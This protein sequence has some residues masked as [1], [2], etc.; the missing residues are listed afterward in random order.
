[1]H[2]FAPTQCPLLTVGFTFVEVKKQ[3]TSTTI[4]TKARTTA[5]ITYSFHVSYV[6]FPTL[7]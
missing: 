2:L 3:L 1:M 7:T 5:T 4:T 6:R